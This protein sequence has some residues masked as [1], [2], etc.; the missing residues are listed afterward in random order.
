[1]FAIIDSILFS[2]YAFAVRLKVM[3]ITTP[4]AQNNKNHIPSPRGIVGIV[5][6]PDTVGGALW[7][8]P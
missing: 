8:R 5:G 6:F 7:L 3:R 2:I 1:M 4:T